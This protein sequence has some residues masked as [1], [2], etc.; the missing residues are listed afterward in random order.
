VKRGAGEIRLP[1]N[2]PESAV[3]SAT[4]LSFA[5]VCIFHD[6]MKTSRNRLKAWDL[7]VLAEC[8]P[9]AQEAA[10]GS[11]LASQAECSA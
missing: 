10:L 2:F 9:S 1:I 5:C 11:I 4:L 6:T 8:L 7:A 3:G